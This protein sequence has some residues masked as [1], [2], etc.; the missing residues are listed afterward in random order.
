MQH[1]KHQKDSSP[2]EGNLHKT[3]S[4][5]HGDAV[6][7]APFGSH[8][9]QTRRMDIK[10]RCRMADGSTKAICIWGMVSNYE[11]DWS[12]AKVWRTSLQKVIVD[13]GYPSCTKAAMIAYKH[14]LMASE[15]AK[16]CDASEA[17]FCLWLTKA[18]HVCV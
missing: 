7:L 13:I 16:H 11:N 18:L 3:K 12:E 6:I 2:Q 5:K 14:V 10:A 4:I 15:L 8:N 1:P 17:S 9:D